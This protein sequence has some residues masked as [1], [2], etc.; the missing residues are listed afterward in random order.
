MCYKSWLS[1]ALVISGLANSSYANELVDSYVARLSAQ[2]HF[3]SKGV[4]LESVA[5]IIRQDRANYHKFNLR[6]PEDTYDGVF[7]ANN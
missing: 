2:D 6:D 3:N 7:L 4:R 5:A 1:V